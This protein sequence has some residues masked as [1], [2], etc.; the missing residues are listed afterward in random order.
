MKLLPENVP[1]ISTTQAHAATNANRIAGVA[2]RFGRNDAASRP[3]ITAIMAMHFRIRQRL[4]MS[5]RL[6]CIDAMPD[7][8]CHAVENDCARKKT[9]AK[10][11]RL[12]TMRICTV[13]LSEAKDLTW[14]AL[15]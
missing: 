11:V 7:R 12:K 10:Q 15:D 13:I 1:K 6:P 14:S 9:H 2:S 5:T 8:T 4:S 3:S